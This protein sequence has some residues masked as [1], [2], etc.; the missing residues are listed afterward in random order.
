MIFNDL[1]HSELIDGI[2][3]FAEVHKRKIGYQWR[4]S[5]MNIST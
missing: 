4:M 5:T 2:F 3:C 1:I